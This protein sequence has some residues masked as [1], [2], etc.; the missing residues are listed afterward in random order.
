MKTPTG[1]RLRDNPPA[2]IALRAIQI[3]IRHVPA[4]P[5]TVAAPVRLPKDAGPCAVD[6]VRV[7]SLV[8]AARYGLVAVR[9][10]A[11][12]GAGAAGAAGGGSVGA[13]SGGHLGCY[14]GG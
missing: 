10:A 5:A 6:A 3:H 9:A 2:P 13:A 12:A 11:G 14:H 8:A 1:L 7:R 4:R